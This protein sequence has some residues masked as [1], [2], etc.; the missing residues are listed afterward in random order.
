[1]KLRIEGEDDE[2]RFFTVTYKG[3]T[4]RRVTAMELN[5]HDHEYKVMQSQGYIT[6]SSDD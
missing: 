2:A 6:R 3:R 4:L 5:I 1:M